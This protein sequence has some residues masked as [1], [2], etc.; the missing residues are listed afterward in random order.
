MKLLGGTWVHLTGA[1]APCRGIQGCNSKRAG[2]K[3]ASWLGMQRGTLQE[4][5]QVELSGRCM[6]A[7]CWR[8]IAEA[9]MGVH[10]PG[11]C[12]A[13]PR[14]SGCTAVTWWR[15][16]RESSQ[17]IHLA[18]EGVGTSRL[19]AQHPPASAPS[20]HRPCT[21]HASGR[22]RPV[23][24]G[25]GRRFSGPATRRSPSSSMRT[26]A[27]PPRRLFSP[28]RGG[29]RRRRGRRGT[30]RK[31]YRPGVL[32]YG[33]RDLFRARAAL[34]TSRRHTPPAHIPNHCKVFPRRVAAAGPPFRGAPRWGA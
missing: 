5:T 12:T 29:A 10:L 31:S 15:A 8:G 34:G 16:H 26:P 21:A 1:C 17:G 19:P 9:C 7:L 25:R 6:G 14:R 30:G 33:Q 32:M 23:P 27:I 24:T 28:P 22:C 18:G 20:L 4:E 2:C 3:D 13:A 11:G